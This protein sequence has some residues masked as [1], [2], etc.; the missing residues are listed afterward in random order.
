[1]CLLTALAVREA[2]KAG[3]RMSEWTLGA[4]ASLFGPD[5]KGLSCVVLH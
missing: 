5:W 3:P 2:G 1:M 4:K